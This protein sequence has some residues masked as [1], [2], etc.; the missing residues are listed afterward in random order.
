MET[1]LNGGV[2]STVSSGLPLALALGVVLDDVP[3]RDLEH[4]A[5]A[6]APPSWPWGRRS[7]RRPCRTRRSVNS[8]LCVRSMPW[9][10][11]CTRA[12]TPRSMPP[13]TSCFRYSFRRDAHGEVEVQVVVVRPWKG[14]AAGRRRGRCSRACALTRAPRAHGAHP[15]TPPR[16]HVHH[17][18]LDL[19]E[20]T[21]VPGKRQRGG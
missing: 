4:H 11:N 14:R 16:D 3:R 19:E 1:R 15:V 9:L 10:R 12:R 5:R 2:K 17:G 21:R 8:G 18:R 6:A 13:I 20:A 7:P